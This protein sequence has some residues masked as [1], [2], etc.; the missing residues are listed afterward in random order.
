GRGFA[1]RSVACPLPVLAQR[2]R[3]RRDE[4]PRRSGRAHACDP[5]SVVSGCGA[6]WSG[7]GWVADL[8]RG[9]L[10]ERAQDLSGGWRV[11]GGTVEV[12]GRRQAVDVGGAV[13]VAVD[14]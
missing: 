10:S 5:D 11:G 3:P 13:G 7:V 8:A 4:A 12:R 14:A 9:R 6:W 2:G 1:I